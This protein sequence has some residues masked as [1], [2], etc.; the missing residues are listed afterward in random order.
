[1][2]HP[3]SP[4]LDLENAI[5]GAAF[6]IAPEKEKELA[7]FRDLQG[8]SLSLADGPA[9]LFNV[10]PT[11]REI[12]TNVATLEFLWC[13]AHAHLIL[14][15]EYSKAQ[16]NGQAKFDTGGNPRSRT[17]LELLNWS[18]NNLFGQGTAAWPT[19][20]PQPERFPSAG[21]DIHVANELFLCGIAWIIHH[22]LAHLRLGH[23]PIRSNRSMIEEREADV[24]ATRWILTESKVPQESRK[25]AVGIAAAILAMQGIQR[26]SHFSIFDTHPRTFERIDHCL[27]AAGVSEDDEVY[28]F[29]ACIM[30]IQLA[31]R[32]VDLAPDA[33]CFKDLFSEYL[34]AFARG[35]D[36]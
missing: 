16:R 7:D 29:A 22:E 32:G 21:T 12:S 6:R 36:S 31:S 11:S 10:N 4:V 24:E 1:M 26:P 17:A 5:A 2:P 18:V 9:F 20:A 23:T 30:Q 15:D 27:T 19:Q 25:R 3:R 28:A 13:S 34:V 33:K 8:V 14:Y 35:N